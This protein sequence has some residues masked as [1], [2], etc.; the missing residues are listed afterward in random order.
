MIPSQKIHRLETF[1]TTI[2]ALLRN[3]EGAATKTNC[4]MNTVHNKYFDG[5]KKTTFLAKPLTLIEF[6][7]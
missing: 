5:L 1:S 7:V 3:L 4:L 2:W 6:P